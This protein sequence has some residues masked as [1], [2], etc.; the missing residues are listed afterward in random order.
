M[1]DYSGSGSLFGWS[2]SLTTSMPLGFTVSTSGVGGSSDGASAL[3]MTMSTDVGVGEVC[4][5]RSF[6]LF[7]LR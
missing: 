5:T 4:A 7:D 6:H 2:E 3:M 1:S